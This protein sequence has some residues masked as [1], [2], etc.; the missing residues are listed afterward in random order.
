MAACASRFQ[1]RS[2]VDK[3]VEIVIGQRTSAEVFKPRALLSRFAGTN[4]P[5]VISK[6]SSIELAEH[7]WE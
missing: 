4:R 3:D 7:A 5:L 1:V 6:R 2:R